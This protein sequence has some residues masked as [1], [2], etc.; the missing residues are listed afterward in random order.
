MC[1]WWLPVRS[2]KHSAAVPGLHPHHLLLHTKD[3]SSSASQRSSQSCKG[4]PEVDEEVDEV[5]SDFLLV[6][7]S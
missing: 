5:V 6:K 1:V 4:K 2:P 7:G 3:S